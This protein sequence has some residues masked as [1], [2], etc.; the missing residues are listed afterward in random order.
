MLI[1]SMRLISLSMLEKLH[2]QRDWATV[3]AFVFGAAV[4]VPSMMALLFSLGALA[5]LLF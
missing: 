3:L 1:H 2:I 4:I 5:R